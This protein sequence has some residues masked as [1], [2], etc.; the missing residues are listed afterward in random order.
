M[1]DISSACSSHSA[2]PLSCRMNAAALVVRTLLLALGLSALVVAPAAAQFGGGDNPFGGGDS[3]DDPFGGSGPTETTPTPR[4]G[5]PSLGEDDAAVAAI[6]ATNPTTPAELVDAAKLLSDLGHSEPAKEYLVQLL[7]DKPSEADLVKMHQA[8]GSGT[9]IALSLRKE[10][11]PESQQIANA[12]I[13]AAGR[14]ARGP[15]AIGAALQTLLTG[16]PREQRLAIRDLRQAGEAA[17]PALFAALADPTQA[18]KHPRVRAALASLGEAAIEPL[19]GALQSDDET[20]KINALRVLSEFGS[21]RALPYLLEPLVSSAGSREY[22]LAARDAILSI[23]DELPT[24]E[25]AIIYLQRSIR[26]LL[27]RETPVPEDLDGLATIWAWNPEA[28]QVQPLRMPARDAALVAAADLADDLRRLDPES[29]ATERLFLLTSLESARLAGG[30]SRPLPGSGKTALELA[31]QAGPRAVENVLSAA[32]ELERPV[33][34]SAAAAL[35]GEIAEAE[36]LTADIRPGPLGQA[37]LNP[38]PRVRFSAATSI[39][40]LDP[41]ESYPSSSQFIDALGHFV[42]GGGPRTAIVAHPRSETARDLAAM[43]AELGFEVETAAT[44][45]DLLARAAASPDVQLI[46]ASELLSQ[47]SLLETLSR[48]RNHPWSAL[49]PV[50]VVGKEESLRR[51]RPRLDQD[52]LSLAA[53]QP[54][55]TSAMNDMLLRL[56]QLDRAALLPRQERT[57]NAIIALD[58]LSQFAADE[59]TYGFYRVRRLQPTV[60]AATRTPALAVSAV[61]LLG[62]LGDPA[63][64]RALVD[65]ASSPVTPLPIRNAAVQALDVAV[66]RRGLLLTQAELLRQY[67]RYNASRDLDAETQQVLGRVLDILE[68]R[69]EPEPS[70]TSAA[71]NESPAPPS[72]P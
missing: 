28:K 20:L 33:A 62:L 71:S 3:T 32:M 46:V 36:I 31:Q 35:L 49:T 13:Q 67:D 34:A 61:R 51:I 18:D 25:E 39:S 47:P 16:D 6:R 68:S 19:I 48:L 38:H 5:Q 23:V 41:R 65:V 12:A 9:L 56:L 15:E 11:Q 69:V 24:R 66:E 7:A 70:T 17:T 55:S 22:R 8:V 58:T 53:L 72:E 14:A 64:Q 29:E 37:L 44:G 1:M 52:P 63:S 57:I 2:F 54:R 30:L 50:G 59:A 26:R 27:D 60:E 42:R 10:L 21:R 40:R 4:P 45:R 43:L